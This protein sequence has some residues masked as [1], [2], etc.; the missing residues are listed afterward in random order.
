MVLPDIHLYDASLGTSGAAWDVYMSKEQKLLQESREILAV[1]IDAI[2][3]AKPDFVL[4]PGDLTKDGEKQCHELAAAAL[5][6][7]NQMG[8]K[9]YVLPGNHDIGNPAALRYLPTGEAEPVP[10]VSPEEFARIYSASGYG[11]ALY[12]DPASLS[13]VAEPVPG[14]WILALDCAKY[15]KNAKRERPESSGAIRKSTYAWIE[16]RLAEASKKGVAVLA[17]EHHPLMEHADGMKGKHPAFIVDDNWKL[18]GLLAGYNVRAL[19]SGHFHANSVVQ[20]RWGTDAPLWLQGKHITDIETGSLVTWP[21]SYRSVRL[22]SQDNTMTI[23]TFRVTQLPSYAAEGKSFDLDGKERI[24]SG[25]GGMIASTMRKVC[26]SQRDIDTLVPQIVSA[27]MAHYAGDARFESEE[28]LTSKGL[29]LIGKLG[30]A[31]YGRFIRGL[32][33]IK[34]PKNVELMPDNNLTIYPN[35]AWRASPK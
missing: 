15:E 3:K 29:S 19:F 1:A 27:M 30:V 24:E 33:K 28:T 2:K 25:L 4:F 20:R 10:G 31:S 7:L 34:A 6:E 9:T 8:I 22:S 11:D 13:Y 14:L 23:S 18:A 16:A 26:A 5:S 21:C 17:A 12:R 35:G 32:W